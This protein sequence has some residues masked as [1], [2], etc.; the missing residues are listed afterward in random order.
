M[1]R[2]IWDYR[3]MKWWSGLRRKTSEKVYGKDYLGKRCPQG[4]K[5]QIE[6]KKTLLFFLIII[7]AHNLFCQENT[8]RYTTVKGLLIAYTKTGNGPAIVLLHGFTQD[9]RVWKK[10]IESVSKNFTVIAWDAP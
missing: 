8:I 2:V 6:M 10:Q 1:R 7:S 5:F 9:S 4:I 3:Q